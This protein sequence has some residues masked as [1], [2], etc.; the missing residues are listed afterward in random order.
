[1]SSNDIVCER[2]SYCVV[3]LLYH[4]S[5]SDLYGIFLFYYIVEITLLLYIMPKSV[6]QSNRY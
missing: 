3:T 4:V 5:F 1:M 6:S 2:I